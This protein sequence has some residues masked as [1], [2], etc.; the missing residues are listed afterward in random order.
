[1]VEGECRS[2]LLGN[3]LKGADVYTTTD[4]DISA[5]AAGGAADPVKNAD[6]VKNEKI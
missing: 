5:I 1:M 6:T 2:N 4:G 3:V